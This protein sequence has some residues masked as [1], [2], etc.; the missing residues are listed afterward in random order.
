M[1]RRPITVMEDNRERLLQHLARGLTRRAAAAMVGI[2]EHTVRRWETSDD[3]Y[4]QRIHAAEALA[5]AVMEERLH[6]ASQDDWRAALA[7]LE[8]RD[9]AQWGRQVAVENSGELRVTIV[10]KGKDAPAE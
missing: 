6:A 1:A 5:C 4:A 10:R 8:R 9:R 3:Q 7:Y 2:D